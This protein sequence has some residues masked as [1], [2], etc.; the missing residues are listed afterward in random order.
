MAKKIIVLGATGDIGK[1]ALEILRY[2]YDYEVVGVA[3]KSNYSLIEEELFYFENLKFIAISS[4]KAAEEFVKKHPAFE[5]AV[6]VGDNAIK[7]LLDEY[8]NATVLNAIS[9]ND[10]IVPTLLALKNNQDLLLAN[11]ESYVVG[12]SLMKERL[13]TYTGHIYPIDSEH[14]GLYK[15]LK[16]TRKRKRIPCCLM[17]TASGGAL[18]DVPLEQLP[19]QKKEDVLKHPTWKMSNKITVDCSTM[20]NKGYEVIE[21]SEMFSFPL[22]SILVRICR[23]SLIHA[24]VSSIDRKTKK[25][26]ANYE[27]SPCSMKT[28]IA[29]SLSKGKK[30]IHKLDKDETKAL[31]KEVDNLEE[32]DDKRYPLFSL[33]VSCFSKYGN[34]GMFYYNAVDTKAIEAFLCDE[35]S[36]YEIKDVLEY[37]YS[38]MPELEK[39]TEENLNDYILR[40]EKYASE[41]FN[42]K[43]WRLK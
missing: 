39:L 36:Y 20:V 34:E 6:F 14:V 5:N 3:F 41:L 16:E 23:D 10:G 12:S 33:T 15:C 9:G 13:K 1:Q 18:R 40:S 38:H 7:E 24:G 37:V 31:E 35:I 30:K 21:A 4:H 42:K 27:Y 22:D 26:I 19:Y 28:A 25:K 8:P 17:I 29:F 11:K 43:S 2:N 32:V